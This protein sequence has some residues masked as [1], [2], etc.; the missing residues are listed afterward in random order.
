[1]AFVRPLRDAASAIAQPWRSPTERQ[2]QILRQWN[3]LFLG[4]CREE[5]RSALLGYAVG[6]LFGG[7]TALV[8]EN[9]QLLLDIVD[10]H[11]KSYRLE[12][13]RYASY[14]SYLW[15][16]A[17]PLLTILI[18]AVS[19]RSWRVAKSWFRGVVTGSCILPLVAAATYTSNHTDHP[20]AQARWGLEWS[21]VIFGLTY[22][23]RLFNAVINQR[24]TATEVAPV[25]PSSA[26]PTPRDPE[27]P[28]NSAREDI[29]NRG[30]LVEV[31]VRRILVTRVPVLALRGNF[32]DGK[33]SVLNML[34]EQIEGRC[35]AISF[36]AWLPE[37]HKTLV[38]DLVSDVSTE[39]GRHYFAPDIRSGLNA[40]ASTIADSVSYLKLLP[41]IFPP[42]T[43][44][45]EIVELQERLSRLP[46]R[47]VVL[48]DEIDRMQ[49]EELIT[50]LKFLR[51]SSSLPNITFVCAFQQDQVERTACDE[52][53]AR[54]TEYMEKF[55]PVSIDLPE[56]SSESLK[57]VLLEELF[58][59]FQDADWVFDESR[60]EAFRKRIDALWKAGLDK[61]C[62]N[63]RK[64]K[65]FSSDVEAAA[66]MIGDEVDAVDL[67]AIQA[68][69]KFQPKGHRLVWAN[70]LFFSHSHESWKSYQP[71]KENELESIRKR[72]LAFLDSLASEEKSAVE[73][74]LTF[75]FPER[76]QD[77]S[78]TRPHRA[79]DDL[80]QSE[81]RRGISHPD[82]FPIYFN[83]S[84]PEAVFSNQ[85]IR[86]LIEKVKAETDEAQREK[87]IDESF[88]TL[89]R[90]SLREFDFLGKLN[91]AIAERDV[92]IE[93]AS[94]A[95]YVISKRSDRLSDEFLASEVKKGLAI[96]FTVAQRLAESDAIN[97]FLARCIAVSATDHFA[98]RIYSFVTDRR[99]NNN[100][101][102]DDRKLDKAA[103]A[104]ALKERMRSRYG[105]DADAADRHLAPSEMSALY[106]WIKKLDGDKQDV[107][108]FFERYVSGS[109][110]RLADAFDAI[111]PI[112]LLWAPDSPEYVELLFPA[113]KLRQLL[114]DTPAGEKLDDNQ[115]RAIRRLEAYLNGELKPGMD[116]WSIE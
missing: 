21:L 3:N 20:W 45:Q 13:N 51:G 5:W 59:G 66:Q 14:L 62:T 29:L 42:Y 2:A 85:Q 19:S 70:A 74:I 60:L 64:C 71:L 88:E 95:A 99:E 8:R 83:R 109:R 79:K 57:P 106:N 84:V 102:L 7:L 98:S 23:I 43:Q 39:V 114:R 97:E 69:Q 72:I 92:P 4:F 22:C 93:V 55:F 50:L 78:G 25:A 105:V 63:L 41:T 15:I 35:I 10:S 47:V 76:M 24:P 96:V 40:F 89:E 91:A 12:L 17:I 103:L 82:Y 48:L 90:N 108:A 115:E 77:L 16:G 86:D 56:I 94:S 38:T 31:L 73:S 61:L 6:I 9:F 54:S 100:V 107:H 49:K 65:L 75:M 68:L 18:A 53:T 113:E 101:L 30:A 52:F 11:V 27:S 112:N 104:L 1:M 37:S 58:K 80:S 36:S 33:S 67:C 111:V 110:R 87:V 28:I 46:K 44:R 32:G 26:F 81:A 34:R 116:L